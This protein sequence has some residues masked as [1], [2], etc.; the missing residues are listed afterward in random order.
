MAANDRPAPLHFLETEEGFVA[1]RWGDLVVVGVYLVPSRVQVQIQTEISEGVKLE[2]TFPPQ[3]GEFVA[4]NF[5]AHSGLWG[6]RRTNEKSA[7][8]ESWATV[9]G[10]CCLNTGSMNT[11]V[12][13]RDNRSLT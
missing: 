6:S 9:L 7:V 3:S 2:I 10:L 5:N 12:K 8:L 11:C 13:P 4:G 1:A